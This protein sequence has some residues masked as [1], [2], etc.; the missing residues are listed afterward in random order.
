[1]S[2]SI[3]STVTLNTRENPAVFIQPADFTAIGKA[4]N[5]SEEVRVQ[6]YST[7]SEQNVWFTCNIPSQWAGVWSLATAFHRE[8]DSTFHNPL[9]G[10]H[11][12]G[13]GCLCGYDLPDPELKVEFEQKLKEYN[14]LL[15]NAVLFIRDCQTGMLESEKESAFKSILPGFVNLQDSGGGNALIHA[16]FNNRPQVIALLK[17]LKPDL[18]LTTKCNYTALEYCCKSSNPDC[19]KE[20]L[21]FEDAIEQSSRNRP[22]YI[23]TFA[24]KESPKVRHLQLLLDKGACIN[25]Q[26]TLHDAG[27]TPLMTSCKTGVKDGF[28]KVRF[29]LDSGANVALKNTRGN[30]ALH[31]AIAY[32]QLDSAN[33]LLQAGADS[34][35]KNFSKKTP[36]E[37]LGLNMESENIITHDLP[38]KAKLLAQAL[39]N[40][41]WCLA[42]HMFDSGWR[43]EELNVPRA[44]KTKYAALQKGK[45]SEETTEKE[46]RESVLFLALKV[47]DIKAAEACGSSTKMLAELTAQSRLTREIKKSTSIGFIQDK[48][49]SERRQGIADTDDVSDAEDF[50]MI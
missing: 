24:A 50:V 33:A 30:T 37:C 49:D 40:D 23:T 28:K 17:K 42:I 7:K 25:G 34:T 27:V 44:L 45:D 22:S 48:L 8:P 38:T 46:I 39:E 31:Y 29:L 10:S 4:K 41:Y 21:E 32:G 43:L 26:V 1:M 18:S 12:N 15:D 36:F 16:C 2:S 13:I 6:F 9:F 11:E 19:L 35:E 20:L 14:V 47:G 5:N 3:S